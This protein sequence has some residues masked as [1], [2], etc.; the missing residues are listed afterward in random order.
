MCFE[1]FRFTIIAMLMESKIPF[2]VAMELFSMNILEPVTIPELFIAKVVK[3]TLDLQSLIP[4]MNQVI[5]PVIMNQVI[6]P[7]SL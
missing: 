4:T 1:F 3:D 2:I 5:I 7:V 6:I